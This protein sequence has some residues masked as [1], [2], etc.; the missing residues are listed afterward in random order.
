MENE[1]AFPHKHSK[2]YEEIESNMHSE[3]SL[4]ASV[5]QYINGM[6][7]EFKKCF[8]QRNFTRIEKIIK[9]I[10]NVDPESNV[11][12][13]IYGQ[14]CLFRGQGAES[15]N[16]LFKYAQNSA[17]VDLWALNAMAMWNQFSGEYSL[18]LQQF[19]RV[20]KGPFSSKFLVSVLINAAKTKKRLGFLDRALEYFERLQCVPEGFKMTLV[21]KLETIHIYILKKSYDTALREIDAYIKFSNNCF[22]RRLRVYILY[23]QKNHKEVLK[24]RKDEESDPYVSYILAR[25]GLENPR[26]FNVDISYCLDEAI[27]GAKDNKYIYNT[28]GNYYYSI[29]RFSDA[30]EQYNNALSIDPK[31]QPAISNLELFVKASSKP[32]QAIY[33]TKEEGRSDCLLSDVSPDIEELNFLDTWKLMGYSSFKIDLHFLKRSPSLKYYVLN[34]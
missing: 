8:E 12:N 25:V 23:L 13:S 11:L 30:A 6:Y 5:R 19:S 33:V 15:Y 2:E 29:N 27:K 20:L 28:Y 26:A 18:A 31:F 10:T 34:E 14:L 16:Y 9:N 4:S 17:S 3:I 24:Y 32:N 21:I 1:T 22:I 7:D